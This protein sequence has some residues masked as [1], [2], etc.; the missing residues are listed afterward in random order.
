MDEETHASLI[1]DSTSPSMFVGNI[2]LSVFKK[3]VLLV[4]TLTGRTT[5]RKGKDKKL[6]E[7]YNLDNQELEDDNDDEEVNNKENHVNKLDSKK[8]N[9]CKAYYIH[10]L[11]HYYEQELTKRQMKTYN[12]SEQIA[13]FKEYITKKISNLKPP[14][15]SKPK[16]NQKYH[17]IL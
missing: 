15:A 16:K 1:A 14:K 7:K 4:S 3:S 2:L 6:A 5:N 8:V 12:R 11:E 9:A 13:N 10:W 17:V